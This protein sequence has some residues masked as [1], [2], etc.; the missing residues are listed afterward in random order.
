MS[1][2]LPREILEKAVQLRD[3]LKTV[4]IAL[5]STGKPCTATEIAQ[6]VGKQRAYVS[7]RLNQLETMHLVESYRKGRFK[8]FKVVTD[9]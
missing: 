6:L 5:Y 1:N 4:F 9:A 2:R 8:L 3:P 7:M